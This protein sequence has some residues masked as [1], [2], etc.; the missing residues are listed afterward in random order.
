MAPI[1]P[2]LSDRPELMEEV[3]AAARAAGAAH[4]W[5][6]VLYLRPGTREHFLESLGRHWPE[7][8][9]SYEARYRGRAHLPAEA[10]Q[11]IL[12]TVSRLKARHGVGAEGRRFLSPPPEPRQ[13][14]LLAG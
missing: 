3:V 2:G 10:T 9:P 8:L 7:L 14:S 11:P 4:L 13:L 1:L 6:G 12:G 5:A